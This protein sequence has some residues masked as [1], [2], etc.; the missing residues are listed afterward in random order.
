MAYDVKYPENQPVPKMTWYSGKTMPDMQARVLWKAR[1]H[2]K[3]PWNDI[4]LL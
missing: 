2:I 4:S 3:L 1:P